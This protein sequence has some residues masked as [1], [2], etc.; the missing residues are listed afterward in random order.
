MIKRLLLEL[1]VLI[2]AGAGMALVLW[3]WLHWSEEM[4][5]QFM[6]YL[7]VLLLLYVA[8]SLVVD[9]T[10]TAKR[11]EARPT[12]AD[13]DTPGEGLAILFPPEPNPAAAKFLLDQVQVPPPPKRDPIAEQFLQPAQPTRH[14]RRAK[15]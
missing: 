1:L 4:I 3:Q 13:L 5:W 6:G 10:Q 15:R 7:V 12:R 8:A 11:R 14:G 9:G 2:L